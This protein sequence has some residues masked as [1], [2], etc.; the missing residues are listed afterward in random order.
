M[1]TAIRFREGD[2]TILLT[3]DLAARMAERVRRAGVGIVDVLEAALAPVATYAEAEW[4]GPRGVQ[5]RTGESGKIDQTLTI[6]RGG[7]LISVGIG[8][9]GTRIVEL[10]G[11]NGSKRRGSRPYA[12]FVQSPG[13]LSSTY[14][15]VTRKEYFETDK[16]H[17]GP[18]SRPKGWVDK[19][20]ET[21]VFPVIKVHEPGAIGHG[22]L[23]TKLVK[24]PANKAIKLAIPKIA[25]AATGGK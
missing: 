21:T 13:V 19:P 17:R 7:D 4:Y 12:V 18:Y 20:G 16:D 1:G 24:V 8:S 10:T 6:T 25:K 2:A 22:F 9:R 23:L 3:G 14:K 15:S 5:P 11:A